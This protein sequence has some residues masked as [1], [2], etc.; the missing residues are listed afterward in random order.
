LEKNGAYYGGGQH[1]VGDQLTVADFIVYDV[2][3][4]HSRLAPADFLEEFP[5]LR[6]FK[7]R[8]EEVPQ[9]SNYLS[10]DRRPKT[11]NGKSA[12]FDN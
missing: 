4:V 8:M 1:F 6:A 12:F 3:D 10:S 2:L 11:T 5:L 7:Q 9:V